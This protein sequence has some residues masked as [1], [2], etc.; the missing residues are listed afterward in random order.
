MVEE[1]R[2]RAIRSGKLPWP[3][4]MAAGVIHKIN[5]PLN[6]LVNILPDHLFAVA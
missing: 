1:A 5:A 2:E 4:R 6:V 3:G